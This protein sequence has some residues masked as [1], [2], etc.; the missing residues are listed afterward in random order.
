MSDPGVVHAVPR[1]AVPLTVGSSDFAQIC[2]R[3][4]IDGADRLT[5]R[6]ISD[7]VEVSIVHRGSGSRSKGHDINQAFAEQ[8]RIG[9]VK[10]TRMH[11]LGKCLVQADDRYRQSGVLAGERL[12]RR[13]K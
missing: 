5:E 4:E 11:G 10:M 8:D 7:I 3:E 1:D 2:E 6:S 12:A 13:S 9:S